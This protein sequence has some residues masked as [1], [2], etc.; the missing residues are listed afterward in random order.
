MS[1]ARK[2]APAPYWATPKPP[3]SFDQYLQQELVQPI[4]DAACGLA[5]LI[6][7]GIC[8]F[9]ILAIVHW[10]TVGWLKVLFF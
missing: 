6:F 9:P 10:A 5:L 7:A 3:R 4:K 1:C 2:S 8:A